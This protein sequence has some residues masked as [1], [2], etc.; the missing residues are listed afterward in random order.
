MRK[1]R[2]RR[3]RGG[4]PASEVPGGVGGPRGSTAA[5]L[6]P[7]PGAGSCQQGW[8]RRQAGRSER[9]GRGAPGMEA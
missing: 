4:R 3:R 5:P 2:E 6:L 9:Q 7:G 1:R 8:R